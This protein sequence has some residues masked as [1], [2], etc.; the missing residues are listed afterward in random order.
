MSEREPFDTSS[1]AELG[2]MQGFPPPPDKRVTRSNGVNVPPYNR[3][4]YQ[5]MR[6]IWPTVPVRP[7]KVALDVPRAID[8]RIETVEV[9]RQDGTV[10][11]F[12]TFLRQTFTDSFIVIAKGRIIHESYLN[13]MTAAQPHIISGQGSVPMARPMSC[14]IRPGSFLPAAYGT[15]RQ[16]MWPGLQ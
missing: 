13:G 14:L 2:L 1:H 4:A 9:T 6:Q 7:G 8:P 12:G 16:T 11:D 3:W 15:R 10:A 5:N